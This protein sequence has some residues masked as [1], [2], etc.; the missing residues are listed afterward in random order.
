MDDERLGVRINPHLVL[1]WDE[2]EFRATRAGGPGGQHVNTSSTRI[3]VAWNVATSRVLNEAQR[4][5]L[6]QRL[7]SRLSASGVLRLV[8]SSRRSQSQNKEEAITRLAEVVSAALE[9]PRKRVA[10]RP[11]RTSREKRLESKKT[12]SATKRLRRP[13]QGDE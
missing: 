9:V 1:P 8:A 5:R 10:T 13:I 3:E 11:T 2:L 12:R 6:R 7:W 4:A